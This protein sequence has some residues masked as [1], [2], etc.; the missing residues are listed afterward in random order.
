MTDAD[1]AVLSERLTLLAEV[2]DAPMSPTRLAGYRA[3]LNDLALD[4]IV[5]ALNVLGKTSVFF[6]K[7]AE[8][9]D[10]VKVTRQLR[11]ERER[12]LWLRMRDTEA[13]A[14]R[15]EHHQEHDQALLES[16]R[17]TTPYDERAAS[18]KTILTA[19]KAIAGPPTPRPHSSAPQADRVH[20][21]IAEW[22]DG[23]A[24]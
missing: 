12:H 21:Q 10:Q 3:F 13:D 5:T 22:R 16:P 2:L 6:P 1:A 11:M 4:D 17:P 7:P 18:M 20:Q 23:E 19:L 14:R 8:I 9:R 24:R 15:V